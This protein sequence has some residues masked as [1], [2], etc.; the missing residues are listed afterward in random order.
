MLRIGTI[1]WEKQY[2]YIYII[3]IWC[4][5][6][7]STDSNLKLKG[8]MWRD[9]YIISYL[10]GHVTRSYT[11]SGSGRCQI[12]HIIYSFVLFLLVI[13]K[14]FEWTQEAKCGMFG[15]QR[16]NYINDNDTPYRFI[17]VSIII[18]FLSWVFF[19]IVFYDNF[20]GSML[21]KYFNI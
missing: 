9:G 2:I 7:K 18:Y 10:D 4:S 14:C 15:K 17:C 16:V 21:C 13:I 20:E 12:V 3:Y 1:T 6:M 8:S 11:L 19:S 5:N